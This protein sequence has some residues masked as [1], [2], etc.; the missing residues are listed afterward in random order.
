[1]T[2]S[3]ILVTVVKGNWAS[4]QCTCPFLSFQSVLLSILL[5]GR[6]MEI[7]IIWRFKSFL[8][9]QF[10]IKENKDT[11]LTF[12]KLYIRDEIL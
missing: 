12:K 9:I 7:Y 8:V 5:L 6:K 11:V 3:R 10:I 4:C 2:A 1:M